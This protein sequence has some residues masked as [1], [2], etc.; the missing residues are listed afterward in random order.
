MTGQMEI[1]PKF[2]IQICLMVG[3]TYCGSKM[4]VLHDKNNKYDIETL[5]KTLQKAV[6]EYEISKNPH[7]VQK[8]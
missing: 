6:D 7:I 3:S 5:H 4:I 8:E 1:H 2:K